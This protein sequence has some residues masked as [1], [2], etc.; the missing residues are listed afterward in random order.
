MPDCAAQP[1]MQALG[2]GAFGEIFDDAGGEAAGNAERIDD[3][4]GVEPE[5]RADAG[6][7]AHDAENRGRVEAGFVHGLRHHGRQPAHDL[8]ADRDTE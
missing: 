2:P 3:L 5:R 4:L 1:G 8:G 6:G 7:G